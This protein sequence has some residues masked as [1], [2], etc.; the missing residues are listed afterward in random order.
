MR[1]LGP[2]GKLKKLCRERGTSITK[3]AKVSGVPLSS[4]S[5]LWD[6]DLGEIP[7]KYGER[8]RKCFGMTADQWSTFVGCDW[9]PT[10]QDLEYLTTDMRY[11]NKQNK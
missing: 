7:A 2:V 6:D 5:R 8:L 4:L 1:K 11:K 3:L 10:E 9:E